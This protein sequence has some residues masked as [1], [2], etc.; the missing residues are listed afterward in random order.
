MPSI[1]ETQ[2]GFHII[3][4]TDKT[5]ASTAEFKDVK[6]KIEEFLKGQKVNEAIG[7]FLEGAR[8]TAKIEIF[9]K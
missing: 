8:K 4:L 5:P 9:L 3:K 1:V 7:K 6:A 2:F